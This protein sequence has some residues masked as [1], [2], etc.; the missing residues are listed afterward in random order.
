MY[1]RGRGYSHIPMITVISVISFLMI[2]GCSTPLPL[3]ESMMFQHAKNPPSNVPRNTVALTGGMNMDGALIRRY[4]HVHHIGIRD[5]DILDPARRAGGLSVFLLKSKDL[6]INF[7]VGYKMLGLN[8]TFPLIGRNYVTLNA[9]ALSGA[10][11]IFQRPFLDK[12]FRRFGLG[13]SCGI[14]ARYDTYYH[15][16]GGIAGTLV[17]DGFSSYGFRTV[18]QLAGVPEGLLH[19]FY[20]IGYAPHLKHTLMFTGLAVR[21][22]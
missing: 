22:P 10:E 21:L 19:G 1:K 18:I 20:S 4:I 16:S 14:Y 8:T 13:I 3:S 15:W 9:G 5:R 2:T 12:R 6:G 11:A 17:P 7:A